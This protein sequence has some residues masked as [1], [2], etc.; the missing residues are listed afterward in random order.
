[1]QLIVMKKLFVH[2]TTCCAGEVYQRF[3]GMHRP[4]LECKEKHYRSTLNMAVS[5]FLENV[6]TLLPQYTVPL[7][8]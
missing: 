7:F 2:V 8:Q 4:K 6:V 1:M 5:R 3:G